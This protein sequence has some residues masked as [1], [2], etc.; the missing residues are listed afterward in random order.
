MKIRLFIAVITLM[1][2]QNCAIEPQRFQAY[3]IPKKV[4]TNPV[5]LQASANK[6]A[7]PKLRL[8]EITFFNGSYDELLQEAR[9]QKKGIFLDFTATWC[10]PCRLMEKETFADAAVAA[11][12]NEHF[13][14]YKV[15]IDW[16]VGMEIAE[17]FNVKQYPTVVF[18]DAQGKY[19]DRLK[20][21]YA[22]AYFQRAMEQFSK[23]KTL[24]DFQLS[25]L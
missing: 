14:A 3:H 15:D 19:I 22:P 13:L 8:A 2:L 6:T 25:S 9:R 18:L 23:S 12:A 11:I 21:Y 10:G 16:F 7:V 4:V 20:G 24:K 1:F 17:K 5:V